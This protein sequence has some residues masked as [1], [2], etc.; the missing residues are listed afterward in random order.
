MNDSSA[1]LTRVGLPCANS[2]E[3]YLAL[4]D[5]DGTITSKDSMLAFFCF[6]NSNA[7]LLLK[8]LIALPVL[9]LFF[10]KLLNN[11]RA[12]E[13][14]LKIFFYNWDEARI[15]KFGAQFC[16]QMVDSF[17]RESARKR[18]LQ[19]LDAGHE[20]VIVSASLVSWL[21]PWCEQNEIELIATLPKFSQA[22]KF[23]GFNGKN[24]HGQEKVARITEQ[25]S[26]EKYTEIYA[27]GDSSGDT[28]ML[29]LADF[30]EYKPF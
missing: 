30:S 14:V 10:L 18:L 23:D 4:F 29:A 19:H 3:H 2:D 11:A 1:S 15:N 12:K 22:G 26:L 21:K 16:D 5:F 28:Q 9:F 24:C 20:V 8:S 7:S 25:Y 13:L 6:T 17:I 27:Y